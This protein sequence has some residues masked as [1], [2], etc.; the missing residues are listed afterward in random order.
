MWNS[1]RY[2]DNNEESFIIYCHLIRNHSE[3]GQIYASIELISNIEND[4]TMTWQTII[5][6]ATSTTQDLAQEIGNNEDN[7]CNSTLALLIQ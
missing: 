2:T 4:I 1:F 6:A 3:S 5:K 7:S